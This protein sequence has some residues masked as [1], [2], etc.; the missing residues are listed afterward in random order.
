MMDLVTE[1]T[2]QAVPAEIALYEYD[3]Y[4]GVTEY[5]DVK[6]PRW[7]WIVGVTA[8]L[9][10]IALVVSVSVLVTR[11]NNTSNTANEGTSTISA[12]PVQDEIITTT[13]CTFRVIAK[14]LAVLAP[15]KASNL[16]GAAV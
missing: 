9:A 8:I 5:E 6:P 10:A 4:D 2:E 14:A 7:P 3:D 1:I 16:T 12:P 15:P 13:P 11:G